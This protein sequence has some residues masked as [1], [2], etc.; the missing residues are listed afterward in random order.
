MIDIEK[1]KPDC[2][3]CHACVNKCPKKCISMVTD[4]EGFDYPYID[5]NNC[6]DCCLCEKTCPVLNGDKAARKPKAYACINKN[7]AVRMESSSGGV[8]SLLAEFVINHGG[9]V[10]GAAFNDKF[11]VVHAGINDAKELYKLRG[12][13]YVQSRLGNTFCE[14]EE[15]LKHGRLV[16]FSGTPC[17]VAGLLN[18]LSKPYDNLFC[19]DLICHGVPSPKVWNQYLGM[20]N[21]KY[22]GLPIRINFRQKDSGWNLFELSIKYKDSSYRCCHKQ[23]KYMRA[24]L[25]D[26]NLR[27]SCY[28][29][30][31][32]GLDRLSDI[33]LADFWGIG[34]VLKDMDDGKGTSLVIV[35]SEKGNAIFQEIKDDMLFKEAEVSDA[36]SYNPAAYRSVLKPKI[37]EKFFSELDKNDF[38]RYMAKVTREKLHVKLKKEIYFIYKKTALYKFF[39]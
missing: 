21:H 29:C 7:E 6:T 30:Q 17:Q 39:H 13:K 35:N 31:F 37:R 27:R 12:S 24:F 28:S 3:G 10:Y 15:Y 14:I 32:K 2:T 1:I 8:F 36:V 5:K 16:Y 34:N 11:E 23:D 38:E 25:G 18:F 20:L 19:Q 22:K 33:T 26:M 4:K 9:I